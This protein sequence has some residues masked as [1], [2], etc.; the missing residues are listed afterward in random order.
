MP[1]QKQKFVKAVLGNFYLSLEFKKK[2]IWKIRILH[3][4]LRLPGIRS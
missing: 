4:L 2:L 3:F 1:D